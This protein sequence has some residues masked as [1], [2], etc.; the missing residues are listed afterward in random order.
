MMYSVF[1]YGYHG[2][3]YSLASPLSEMWFSILQEWSN[4]TQ[5]DGLTA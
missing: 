4:R 5:F 3:L 2:L 1:T